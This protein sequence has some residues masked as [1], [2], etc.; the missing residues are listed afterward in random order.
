MD[1]M[2]TIGGHSNRS[3]NRLPIRIHVAHPELQR[4]RVMLAQTFNITNLEACLLGR[5]IGF[6]HCHQPASRE[7][8]PLPEL[9]TSYEKLIEILCN[10]ATQPMRRARPARDAVIEEQSTRT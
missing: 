7:N 3:H 2:Q 1:S 8:V 5:E 4:A 10:S 9:Y 6:T